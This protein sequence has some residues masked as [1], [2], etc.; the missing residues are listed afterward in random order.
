MLYTGRWNTNP[1]L[2][3]HNSKKILFS[4]RHAKLSQQSCIN[5]DS[6]LVIVARNKI[7]AHLYI[8]YQQYDG[9]EN[10]KS[11]KG[12]PLYMRRLFCR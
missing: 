7:S 8:I 3:L 10:D 11:I 2:R 5:W 9:N 1:A 6:A 4:L 12:A